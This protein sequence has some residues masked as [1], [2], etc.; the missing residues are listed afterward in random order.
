[1]INKTGI[2]I[3]FLILLIASCTSVPKSELSEAENLKA[4]ELLSRINEI[5]ASS[6]VT[7]S[8]SFTADGNSGEKKFRVEGKV[9]FDKK[10]Y[11]K[12]TV[13]DYVFQSPIIEAFR[14][15]DKLYFYYPA[16]KKLLTDDVNKINL[17]V[18]TG[19]KTEYKLLYTLLT[20]GI[21]LLENYTLY[22]CLYDEKAKGYNLLIQNDDFFENIFFNGDVPEKILIMHKKSRDKMEIYLKSH[23]KKDKSIFFRKCRIVVPEINVSININFLKPVLNTAVPVEKLN[24]DKLPGKVEII[25]VN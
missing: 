11:Y 18:Y 2:V 14:E 19:F 4:T 16:E 17:S 10:G 21:P 5:N 24:P 15:I 12:V 23:V 22:K 1:M 8:S 25:K 9:A 3:L 7:I 20:G 6:P 13:F